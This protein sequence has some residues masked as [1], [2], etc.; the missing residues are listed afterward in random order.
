[1]SQEKPDTG[2]NRSEPLTKNQKRLRLARKIAAR[3]RAQIE[4]LTP[5]E[6]EQLQQEQSAQL[7]LLQKES[8][9]AKII[10]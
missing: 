3:R 6:I 8:P 9:K 4:M 5:S 7:A 2:E 10:R 1:M